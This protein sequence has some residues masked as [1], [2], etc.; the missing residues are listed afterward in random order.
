MGLL[1]GWAA[2]AAAKALRLIALGDSLTAGYGLPG[3]DAFPAVLQRVL[4]QNGVDVEVVNGGVSGDTSAG[5]LAR[6]DWT[7]GDGAD[8]AIVE[9]GANDMLRGAD[10]A[11]TK[12]DIDAILAH[13]RERK[14]PFVIAGMRA[15]PNLGGAYAEQFEPIYRELAAKYQA[16][17]YP[18][19]LDGVAGVKGMQLSD[20]LHPDKAG[21][22]RIVAGILPLIEAWLKTLAAN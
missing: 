21:V 3:D 18:F 13:L 10:P 19:F 15:A 22:E 8:A 6:L 14:I 17:L 2:P 5:L 16:P 9:I 11:G 12:K 4:R 20:G 7:L 1:T